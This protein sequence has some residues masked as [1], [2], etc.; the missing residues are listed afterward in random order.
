MPVFFYSRMAKSAAER[1][2]DRRQRLKLNKKAYEEYKRKD[3]VRKQEEKLLMSAEERKRLRFAVKLAVQKHRTKGKANGKDKQ[4]Q[5]KTAE[6]KTPF[7]PY[8]CSATL[9]KAKRRL[10]NALPKSPRKQAAV[11]A[12]LASDV[13][14]VKLPSLHASKPKKN[15]NPTRYI[16]SSK[17]IL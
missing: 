10:L 16:K 15:R 3:R 11:T 12:A 4:S 8:K 6:S 1:Q 17:R 9:G 14:R 2:R 7:S 5:Q 13:L